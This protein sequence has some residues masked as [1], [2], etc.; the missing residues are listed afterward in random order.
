MHP[1]L[2][3]RDDKCP[4][5][6]TCEVPM[7]RS[8]S[9]FPA[10]LVL[11]ATCQAGPNDWPGWRGPTANG[12]SEAKGFPINWNPDSTNIAWKVEVEGRGHSSPVVWGDRIFVTTDVEGDLIP[13]A[14][15]AVKHKLE[16]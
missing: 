1:R 9:L 13:G 8:R 5:H 14:V 6:W 15:G 11:A 3:F 2:T 10:A 4:I 16:G 7:P 12:L